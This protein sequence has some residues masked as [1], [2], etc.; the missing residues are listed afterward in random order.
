M[1]RQLQIE[2]LRPAQQG[3]KECRGKQQIDGGGPAE[4]LGVLGAKAHRIA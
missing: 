2:A 4:Q 1:H 3:D